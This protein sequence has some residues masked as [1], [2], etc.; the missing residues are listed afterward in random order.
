MAT[1]VGGDSSKWRHEVYLLPADYSGNYD[2]DDT[3]DDTDSEDGSGGGSG[4]DSDSDSDSDV[5]EEKEEQNCAENSAEQRPLFAETPAPELFHGVQRPIGDSS[6]VDVHL[7]RTC[8]HEVDLNAPISSPRSLWVHD[9]D[10]DDDY[11][12]ICELNLRKQQLIRFYQVHQPSMIPNVHSI[13]TQY[14]FKDVNASLKKKYNALPAGWKE[15]RSRRRVSLCAMQTEM[16]NFVRA[17]CTGNII[18]E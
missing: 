18:L 7:E 6:W 4:S 9:V 5:E 11:A 13:L 10:D 8:H 14:K 2:T 1:A 17:M 15:P 12:A 16:G 3:D